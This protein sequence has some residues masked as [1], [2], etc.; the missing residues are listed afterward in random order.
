MPP[1]ADGEPTD[2]R[3]TGADHPAARRDRRRA[4]VAL[5]IV[6]PAVLAGGCGPESVRPHAAEVADGGP[7]CLATDVLWSLG[8]TP[9]RGHDRPGPGAGAVPVG[10]EPVAVVRC[11]GPSDLP[12]TTVEPLPQPRQT[13]PPFDPSTAVQGAPDPEADLPL[14]TGTPV[15]VDPPA[16]PA[17]GAPDQPAA[18]VVEAELRGDLG[19][20]LATLARPSHRPAPDQACPALWESQPVIFLVDDDGRAVRAQWPTDACG[21]LLDGVT[22]PLDAL[23]VVRETPRS[24]ADA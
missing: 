1:T 21:F 20:L 22:R 18:T 6:L 8:L 11:L 19:P 4:G 13:L 7:D 23:E 15:P 12:I 16:T 9:P 3:S 24:L 10:F 5:T 14:A 17:P 2:P